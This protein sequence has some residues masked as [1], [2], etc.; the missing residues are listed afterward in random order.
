MACSL[1]HIHSKKGKDAAD[2]SG[3]QIRGT[4]KSPSGKEDRPLC[5]DCKNGALGRGRDCDHWHP[6]CRVL[7]VETS[8]VTGATE[9]CPCVHSSHSVSSSERQKENRKCYFTGGYIHCNHSHCKK[10]RPE[11]L[12]SRET[13]LSRAKDTPSTGANWSIK[14]STSEMRIDQPRKIFPA[15]GFT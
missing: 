6:P 13:H 7:T 5:F 2:T 14:K 12:T 4:G 1:E 15:N 10:E 11:N 3:V 9:D 8:Q